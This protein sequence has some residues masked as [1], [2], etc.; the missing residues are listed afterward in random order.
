[1]VHLISA[2]SEEMTKIEINQDAIIT[3]HL[4]KVNRIKTLAG[5]LEI[6]GNFLSEE[7]ITAL[8][9]GKKVLGTYE[10][11]LEVEGAIGAYKEFENYNYKDI[12]SLLKAHKLL[13]KDI[14]KTAGS[15]RDVNVGV[16]S[17]DGVAHIAP[18]PHLVPQLMEDLFDW[19]QNSEEHPLI[20]NR[21]CFTINLSLSTLLMMA[22]AA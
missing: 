7:K 16:G 3:P 2:I 17:K 15:F 4:R 1:M 20:K 21:V 19:L 10:E 5:T 13:M 22:M 12:G 9:D 18:P 11:I 8:L 14:L 6:E